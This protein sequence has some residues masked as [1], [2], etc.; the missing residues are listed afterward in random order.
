[1]HVTRY[2]NGVELLARAEVLLETNE[3]ENNLMLGICGSTASAC[4]Y[5]ATVD[6]GDRLVMAAVW[7]SPQRLVLSAAGAQALG[8][9]IAD[10]KHRGAAPPG[11]LGPVATVQAFADEW[12][13]PTKVVMRQAIYQLDKL[14][15]VAMAP[16]AARSPAVGDLPRVA[17][18]IGGFHREALPHDDNDPA[19]NLRKANEV[20]QAGGLLLWARPDGT[21]VA[22]ANATGQTRHGVRVNFVFTPSEERGRGYASA[23]V[24]ELSRR[25]LAA[26]RFCCLYTDLTNPTS[27]RIYQR[28]GY[29]PVSESLVID[30]P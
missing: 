25:Q 17:E 16:G 11:V 23:C 24:A 5:F 20:C 29:Q 6:D 26:G 12:G 18:W 9:L 8:S 28:L 3:A 30:L 22:M 2:A 14:R 21:P 1:V 13:G 15:E 10:L 19:A 7:T 4:A 27:N